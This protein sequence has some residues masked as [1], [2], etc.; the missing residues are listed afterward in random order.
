[1]FLVLSLK[2]VR[3]GGGRK[4]KKIKS[5]NLLQKEVVLIN[6]AMYLEKKFYLTKKGLEKAKKEHEGLLDIKRRKIK[7][8]AP[9]LLH[10]EDLN[11][12][13]L[14]YLEDMELLDGRIAELELILKN[15]QII[16]PP[17]KE[18][19]EKIMPGA[20]V[21]LEIDGLEDEFEI[22]GSFEANPSLGKISNESPV[23]KALLGRQ[24][25]EE[26]VI[27]SPIKTAYKIKKIKYNL[28]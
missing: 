26:F 28:S 5:S 12:E 20:K 4:N 8:E 27:S 21:L 11:P 2:R 19:K 6:K 24:A 7:G 23:G 14:S 25:G 16:L 1:M 15:A 13:Y 17:K 18:D 3:E 10:S 9:E 22:V